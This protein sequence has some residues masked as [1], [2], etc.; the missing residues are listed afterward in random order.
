MLSIPVVLVVMSPF[1]FLALF[2][3]VFSFESFP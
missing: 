1:P 3:W 2:I